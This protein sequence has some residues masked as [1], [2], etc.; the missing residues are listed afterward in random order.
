MLAWPR[1]GRFAFEMSMNRPPC[2]DIALRRRRL[3]F[4]S[5]HRGIREM[6]LI[7]GRFADAYLDSLSSRE[8]DDYER[9]LLISD[10]DL[11]EFLTGFTDI[12]KEHDCAVIRRV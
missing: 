5:W 10:A 7:L 2:S 3:M 4:R 6:D 8:L 12:P 9:L 1:A 11:L